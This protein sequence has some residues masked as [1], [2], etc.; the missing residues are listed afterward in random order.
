MIKWT[1]V[2][3]SLYQG[4]VPMLCIIAASVKDERLHVV[5]GTSEQVLQGRLEAQS[6]SSRRAGADEDEF[7]I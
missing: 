2:T 5:A 1:E 3:T 4:L 6:P 7:F